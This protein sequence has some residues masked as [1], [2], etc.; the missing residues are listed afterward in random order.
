MYFCSNFKGYG[1]APFQRPLEMCRESSFRLSNDNIEPE[2]ERRWNRA[3]VYN[4]NTANVD[5][6]NQVNFRL[7]DAPG[8]TCR[9]CCV[10]RVVF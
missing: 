6:L 3:A 2:R 5:K 7:S 8:G 9:P 1:K 10:L 4:K